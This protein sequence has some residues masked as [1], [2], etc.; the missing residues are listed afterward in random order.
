MEHNDL[1]SIQNETWTIGAAEKKRIDAFELWCYCRMLKVSWVD[2]VTNEEILNRLG[3]KADL[4]NILTARRNKWVGH[5]LRHDGLVKII[6]EGTVEGKNS[7]GRPRLNYIT[8]VMKDKGCNN[9]LELKRLAE[10][11][12]NGR[13]L[14]TNPRVD[15]LEEEFI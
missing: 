12:Q 4:W 6:L 2:R 11:R 3:V 1:C 9:Y 8:Q 15:N 13:L 14:Q 5:L 10:E 7:R